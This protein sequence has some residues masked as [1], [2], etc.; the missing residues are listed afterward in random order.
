MHH[1]AAA[2]PRNHELDGLR[3]FAA[4]AVVFYHAILGLDL[5]QVPRIHAPS[6][7][8]LDG[9][10]ER[11]TKLALAVF[12]GDTAVVIFFIMSGAVLMQSLRR[13]T[14]GDLA[15]TVRFIVRRLLRIY[16][17]LIACVLFA[18]TMHSLFGVPWDFAKLFG[19]L[20]LKDFHFIGPSWTLQVE[21]LAVPLLLAGGLIFRRWRELG[22]LLLCV[23]VL[24]AMRHSPLGGMLPNFA[25]YTLCFVLGMFIPTAWGER[26]ARFTPRASWPLLLIAALF[27]R[28]VVLFGGYQTTGTIQQIAAGLLVNAIYHGRMAGLDRVLRTRFAGFF[29]RI[30]YTLYLAN[31]PFVDLGCMIL[32]VYPQ[33]TSHPLEAGLASGLVYILLT[34]PVACAVTVWIEEP[35][36]RLG[37]R[38]TKSRVTTAGA[39][40][41]AYPPLS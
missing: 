41:A 19:N 16:P 23:A 32:T 27:A 12:N 10:Y 3:G 33:V 1:T 2:A 36:I 24:T 15:V 35:A 13:E 39:G 6:F 18:A 38:L 5:T 20:A 37:R 34:I 31:A 9:L 40:V 8:A 26:V 4:M 7:Q 21:L 22:L 14:A 29:G 30:S 28:H 25:L 11:L 17:A